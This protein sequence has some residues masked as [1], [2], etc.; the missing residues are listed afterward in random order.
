MEY[1]FD[2]K[3]LIFTPEVVE[4]LI[5]FRQLGSHQHEAG[6]IL[7]GRIYQSNKIVI[8]CIS[9]PS[10][11]DRSGR[12]FFDRNVSKA[13]RIV[14]EAWKESNGE[15]RYLGEWHTHPEFF[16][17]PSITDRKLIDGMLND[18]IQLNNNFL[19]LVIVGIKDFYVGSQYRGKKLL[20][21]K[22]Y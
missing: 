3:Q 16:P 12:F 8:E 17:S 21:L 2:N 15:L 18:T 10:E 11:E 9:T 19:F 5:S 20:K 4:G 7:L 13:Q 22:K 1:G 14:N 6:G